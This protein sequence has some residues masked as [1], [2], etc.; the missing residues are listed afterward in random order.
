MTPSAPHVIEHNPW[1]PFLGAVAIH[2]IQWW[3]LGKIGEFPEPRFLCAVPPPPRGKFSEG[4]QV[5]HSAEWTGE[6]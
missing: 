6:G 2:L 3:D 5:G 1:G 4:D